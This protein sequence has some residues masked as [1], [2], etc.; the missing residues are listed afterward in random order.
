M[1]YINITVLT[2]PSNTLS[3]IH[4]NKSVLS[5]FNIIY[6][7]VELSTQTIVWDFFKDYWVFGLLVFRILEY[8]WW[9]F[10]NNQTLFYDHE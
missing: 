3:C 6:I 9:K 10:N 1:S 7:I 4:W 5:G 2:W 8:S